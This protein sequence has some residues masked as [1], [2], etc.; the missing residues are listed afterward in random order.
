MMEWGSPK[1][2]E[3]LW[4]LPLLG[5]I[6]YLSSWRRKGQMRRFGELALIQKLITSFD[7]RRRFAKRSLLLLSVFFLILALAQPHF[8]IKEITVER[9]GVD[10]MI[11]V[12]VSHSMLA[13]DVQPTRL[14][15]AKL[16]LSSLI[17][18]L[19]QDRIGIVAFAGEAFIQCP[20]TLD[21]S[22]V[23]LFLT[24][25]NPSLIPTP[26]TMIGAAIHVATQAFAEKEKEYKAIVLLTDG[27]DQGSNPLQFVK[28]AKENGVRIFTIGIGTGDGGTIPGEFEG[29]GVKKD[30]RGQI[31]ISKLNEHLLKKIAA[32][33]GGAY[34]RS[35]GGELEI[36][37]LSAEIR[38]M[39]QK[40]LKSEKIFEY[41]ENY[42]Y[43]IILALVLLFLE[44]ILSE[45]KR[46]ESA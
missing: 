19:K 25:L 21:R 43:F 31:V 37:S 35:S 2:F 10:V 6:F 29:E 33:T 39:S 7:P 5:G 12:D 18:H 40:G 45:R 41:E 4:I 24:T 27:E 9:K 34:Y 8:R 42:Q 15:K 11:A 16:E 17:D 28:K 36:E 3:W 44:M 38:K 32:E 1:N 30:R 46:H 26:G 13:K 20:L 22:A 23:K 14:D